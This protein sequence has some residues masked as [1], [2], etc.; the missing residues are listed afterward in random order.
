MDYQAKRLAHYVALGAFSAAAYY[1]YRLLGAST[2]LENLLLSAFLLSSSIGGLFV[3]AS[4]LLGKL[5][6]MKMLS[7]DY[8]AYDI[9]TPMAVIGVSV[10][11]TLLYAYY[12]TH[13]LLLVFPIPAMAVFTVLSLRNI[14]PFVG[15]VDIKPFTE[16][17]IIKFVTSRSS[18][19]SIAENRRKY[20]ISLLA[21]AGEVGNPYIL[22]S[23]TLVY[24]IITLVIAVPLA[25][26]L[27]VL[28]WYPFGCIAVAPLFA[29]YL[30]GMRLRDAASQRQEG[31][32]RELPFFSILTTVL[33]TAGVSLYS[34]FETV[35]ESNMFTHI[36]REA[37]LL[38][39][40]VM[41]FGAD[42]V[43]AFERL[44]STHPSKKLSTFLN[45]YTSKVRSGGDMPTYLSGESGTY[46]RNLEE[47]WSRY[48]QRVGLIG[49]MMITV[50]GL[51]PMMLLIVSV[52]TGSTANILILLYTA[53]GVPM[54]TVILTFM[55]GRMQPVGED[56]L[57]G[58]FGRSI[59]LS[60]ISGVLV[61]FIS[62]QVWI[63]LASS[64]F[65]FFTVYGYS[66]IDQRQ[67]MREVDNAMP[68]FMKDL[69]EYKRQEYDLTKAIIDIAAHNTYTPAFDKILKYAAI[70]LA[71]GTPM[72]EITVDPKSRLGR[73]VFLILGQMNR[74]GGGTVET[75]YQLSTY[76]TKV[77]EMRNNTAAEMRPYMYL[78]I[79]SPLMLAFGVTFITGVLGNFNSLVSPQFA[80]INS[81]LHIAAGSNP[82]LK[83]ITDF[84]I[85]V[86]AAG[87]GI[88][89]SKMVDFTVK[90][91]LRASVNVLIAVIVTYV[92]SAIDIPSLLHLAGA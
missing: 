67:Q 57:T 6:L 69:M 43:E 84:L 89:S 44:A 33:G 51:I 35:S 17:K 45:G 64:L 92:L 60:I 13:I 75:F 47:S 21:A 9:R 86:T 65:A 14:Y 40:D 19:R 63:G 76:T 37:M 38:K 29:Y 88:I 15:K 23:K 79:L 11:I 72:D 73:I 20:F 4:S 34:I 87:L 12:K 22:A 70:Q 7:E 5:G 78:A 46:L 90:Y 25:I 53:L 54:F 50:F 85:V 26:M 42:P 18:L 49:S 16:D 56:P 41:I 68:E 48:S 32:D 28:V 1:T 80:H 55:A 52:F 66:V 81:P 36:R 71:T 10:G 91:T 61:G 24:S 2:G 82:Q 83:Q 59:L 3:M 27:G 77:V 74:S 58:R 31:V 30:P 8:A 62:S 39:R